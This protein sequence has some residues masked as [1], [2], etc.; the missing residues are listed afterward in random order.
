M[1]MLWMIES[2]SQQCRRLLRMSR[3]QTSPNH[4]RSA[5]TAPQ[6]CRSNSLQR[7]FSSF[8]QFAADY[9]Y[10]YC[11]SSHLTWPHFI[12]TNFNWVSVL[13][14]VATQPSLPWLWPITELSV[15]MKWGHM[16]WGRMRWDLYYM[17]APGEFLCPSHVCLRLSHY[18][19]KVHLF[20][21]TCM[22]EFW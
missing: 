11:I 21:L 8:Q 14:L 5:L 17:N 3:R 1:L 4:S 19:K 10:L 13:W 2:S 22:N 15:Q 20:G 18:V 12:S 16:R 9:S 6:V 7:I